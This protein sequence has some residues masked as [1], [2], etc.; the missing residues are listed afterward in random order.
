MMLSTVLAFSC[1]AIKAMDQPPIID[2]A[3]LQFYQRY[4]PCGIGKISRFESETSITYHAHL[5][6]GNELTCTSS[7]SPS[8]PQV[9]ATLTEPPE[10]DSTAPTQRILYPTWYLFI[11]NTFKLREQ[12]RQRARQQANLNIYSAGALGKKSVVK[13]LFRV[14]SIEQDRPDSQDSQ[15]EAL[16]YSLVEKY[17]LKLDSKTEDVINAQ[18]TEHRQW[19]RILGA[20]NLLESEPKNLTTSSPEPKK[21]LHQ[22]SSR[23]NQQQ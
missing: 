15:T 1:L 10:N 22:T 3:A 23:Y 2:A 13:E 16:T 12:G 5:F 9:T 14:Q 7:I 6:N 17:C 4:A 11:E 20:L 19:W 21:L 18:L 8:G